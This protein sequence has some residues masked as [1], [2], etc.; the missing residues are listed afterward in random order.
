MN[1]IRQ[2]VASISQSEPRAIILKVN[3]N[4]GPTRLLS[5][6]YGGDAEG[7]D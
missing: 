5:K 7:V 2:M 3:K 4:E 1:T 6:L